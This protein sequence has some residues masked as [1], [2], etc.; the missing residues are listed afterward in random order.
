MACLLKQA[1]MPFSRLF[2]LA[3]L[4]KPVLI[5]AMTRLFAIAT[6]T[7]IGFLASSCCCTMDKKAPRLRS[8]PKFKE[9]PTAPA[10]EAPAPKVEYTK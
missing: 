5:S 7:V 3:D 6:A 10:E 4:K 2:F 1:A 9:I 8:L